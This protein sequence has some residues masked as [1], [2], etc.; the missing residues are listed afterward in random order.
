MCLVAYEALRSIC[1]VLAAGVQLRRCLPAW[2]LSWQSPKRL[3]LGT[4]MPRLV[5]AAGH[6]TCVVLRGACSQH[7][8][9]LSSCLSSGQGVSSM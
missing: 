2:Q 5:L 4:C 1:G 7:A 6:F 3:I 8:P 9:V